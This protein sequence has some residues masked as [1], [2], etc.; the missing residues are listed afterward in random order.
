MHDQQQFM[1]NGCIKAI[2]IHQRTTP[3][4]SNSS[5]ERGVLCRTFSFKFAHEMFKRNFFRF[6]GMIKLSNCTKF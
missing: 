1:P 5:P 2:I 6:K 3:P 4:Q